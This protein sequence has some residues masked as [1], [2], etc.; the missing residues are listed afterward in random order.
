[1]SMNKQ[2]NSYLHGILRDHRF[3]DPTKSLKVLRELEGPKMEW[4]GAEV[5]IVSCR[6]HGKYEGSKGILITYTKNT[7]RIATKIDR[8][9]IKI[10]VV[11]KTGSKIEVKL[12][13]KFTG[14]SAE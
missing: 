14:G 3:D 4:A 1:M 8:S 9:S 6:A 7:W 2:W 12:P 10:R 5:M 11:P 13:A